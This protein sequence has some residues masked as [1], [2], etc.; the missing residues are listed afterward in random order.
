MATAAL[1]PAVVSTMPPIQRI[2]RAPASV[3]NVSGI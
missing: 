3:S 1:R 2:I